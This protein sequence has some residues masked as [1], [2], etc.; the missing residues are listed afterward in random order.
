MRI[1]PLAGFLATLF[2]IALIPLAHTQ[3]S[4]PE[5]TAMLSCSGLPCV[6][7]V[8]GGKHLKL[9]IDTGDV[10]SILDLATARQMGLELKPIKGPDGKPSPDYSQAVLKDVQLGD[11]SLGDVKLLVMDIQTMIHKGQMP[12]VDGSLAYTAFGKLILTLDYKSKRVTAS[13]QAHE[14][15]PCP[16]PCGTM[17]NPTFGKH[18][19]PIVVTTGFALN[20]QPLTMQVDTL[21]S[22]S[23]LIYPTSVDKLGLADQQKST[24]KRNFPYTDGG[25]DM[26]E[27]QAATESF[28][29]K[30]LLK[31]A[32]LYFATPDVHLPDGMFDGTVGQ[33]LFEGHKLTFDF[34]NQHFWII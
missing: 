10:D 21:Y 26:V 32:T 14:A 4:A 12:Q 34:A 15:L 11:T 29:S 1:T 7:A 22:G 19:P 2:G 5:G 27:G 24:K 8:A 28:N 13:A 9:A 20:N 30:T 16:G 6:D 25:V 33:E 31:N 3:T 17:T 18:G 23:M